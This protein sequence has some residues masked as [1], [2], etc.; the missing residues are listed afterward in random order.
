MA[1]PVYAGAAKVSFGGQ[2]YNFSAT[3]E[4]V[5]DA[6]PVAALSPELGPIEN[7]SGSITAT[8]KL[9]KRQAKANWKMLRAEFRPRIPRRWRK[10]PNALKRRVI[11]ALHHNPDARITDV[12]ADLL[13]EMPPWLRLTMDFEG[14]R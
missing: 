7:L 10:H 12:F 14:E 6:R 5:D 4:F 13:R 9:S 1:T 3:H 8:F 11:R 2:S